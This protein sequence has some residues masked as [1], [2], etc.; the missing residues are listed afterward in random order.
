MA[1]AADEGEIDAH[2]GQRL[3]VIDSG[4]AG[5]VP[6]DGDVDILEGAFADHEG[7]GGTAFLGGAAVVADAA[8]EVVFGEPVFHRGGGEE[9][10]G[11]EEVVAAAVA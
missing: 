2:I 8:L 9:G 1:G 3:G 6:G 5:G 4:E 11:A 10:G 7:F